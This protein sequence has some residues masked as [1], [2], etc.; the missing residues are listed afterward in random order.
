MNLRKRNGLIFLNLPMDKYL[1][2]P[3]RAHIA[4]TKRNGRKNIA[5]LPRQGNKVPGCLGTVWE[6]VHCFCCPVA[7]K[8][9]CQGH[10]SAL[11]D[12]LAELPDDRWRNCQVWKRAIWDPSWASLQ[13]NV[14]PADLCIQPQDKPK[15]WC[16]ASFSKLLMPEELAQ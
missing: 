10:V 12:S 14:D 3:L 2:L 6:A 5:Q 8:P 9:S 7:L 1:I 4:L 16:P 15:E 13:V 11:V